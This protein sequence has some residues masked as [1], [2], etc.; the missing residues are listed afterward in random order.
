MK[1]RIFFILLI[2]TL[3]MMLS[4]GIITPILPLYAK[5][6]NATKIELG[7]V[8]SAFAPSSFIFVAIIA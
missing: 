3:V 2:A 6:V 4:L 7:I 8:F 1:K 5:S